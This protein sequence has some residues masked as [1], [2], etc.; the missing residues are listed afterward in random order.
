VNALLLHDFHQNLGAHFLDVNGM[1]AVEHYGDP[2]AEHGALRQSA[3][4]LDLGFRGR[5][6]LLGADRK[7]FLNGQVTNN[8]KDLSV[9]QG[10]YAALVTAK[11]KMESDLNIYCL[12]N[13]LL[14]D[15]EP[16]LSA[17]VQSRLEKY[18]IA[19]DVQIADAAPPYGVLSVQG[20]AAGAIL[21]GL[22]LPAPP[23]PFG[24]TTFPHPD[25]GEIYLANQPRTGAAGFDLFIPAITL[26]AATE[27]VLTVVR[28]KGGR[29]CGWAALEMARIEVGLPRF[30]ADMDGANLPPEAGLDNRA[31][32]YSKGCYI[33]QEVIARIRTY[34]QVAKALR[35]LRLPDDLSELPKKGDKLWR[36]GKE[37]GYITS[38]IASPALKANIALAYVR[39]E[40][41]TLGTQLEIQTPGRTYSAI[42]VS[43]PFVPPVAL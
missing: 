4:L 31:V 24:I 39:K 40:A 34:G 18:I 7:S 29:T 32:S 27:K 36:D 41:N 22:G 26:P 11:G 30:G 15:F 35:G 21:Q 17:A 5:L 19:E 10:C 25:L 13:E 43:L 3:G 16:G 6:C 28:A 42:I 8:V 12:E 1:E 20:P 9:G 37:T 23:Q 2:L 33:G 38:A 14:L